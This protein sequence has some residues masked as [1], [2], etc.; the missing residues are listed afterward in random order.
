[1]LGINRAAIVLV[2]V[3]LAL[4]AGLTLA[5][6]KGASADAGGNASCIGFEA[7]GISPPGSSDEFTGGL[8]EVHAFIDSLGAK[9]RGAVISEVAQEHLRSHEA[10]D[11]A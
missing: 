5:E 3:A 7:S 4:F 10:C 11:A 8:P 2:A 9:N 6:T 1:M